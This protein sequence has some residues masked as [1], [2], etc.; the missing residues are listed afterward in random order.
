M[1]DTKPLKVCIRHPKAV[2]YD[3]PRC[4]CCKMSVERRFPRTVVTKVLIKL[5]KH[6]DPTWRAIYSN[7]DED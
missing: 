5:P 3:E 2:Y 4:S 1:R 6:L 7:E